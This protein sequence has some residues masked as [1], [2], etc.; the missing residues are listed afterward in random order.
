MH[1][2]QHKFWANFLFVV[3][4]T[5]YIGGF[6]RRTKNLFAGGSRKWRLSVVLRTAFQRL[7]GGWFARILRPLGLKG[8]RACKE[9][10][11][12]ALPHQPFLVILQAANNITYRRKQEQWKT[13]R[14]C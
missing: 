9:N 10:S 11:Q 2:E 3:Q 5:I 7:K 14:K 1:A 6:E 4:T 8:R 13:E 12:I